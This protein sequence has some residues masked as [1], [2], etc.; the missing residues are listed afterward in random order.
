MYSNRAVLLWLL[1][2]GLVGSLAG[3][4]FTLAVLADPAAGGPVDPQSVWVAALR[5]A[6][7]LLAPASAVG[8][9]FGRRVGLGAV[10]PNRVVPGGAGVWG[11]VRPILGVS[12]AVGL[13]IAA[14]GIIGSFVFQAADFGP[15]LGNPTPVDWLARSFSAALTEEIVFRLGLMT[16]LVWV[17]AAVVRKAG[18]DRSVFWAGNTLAALVGASFHLPPLLSAATPNWGLV[19]MVVLFSGLA[20]V[21]LGWL[22]A[23]YSLVSAMLAHFVA[24]FVQHVIPRTLAMVSGY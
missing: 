5:E 13:A 6:L 19:T 22:Y 15:G 8:L 12:V 23:R 7:L 24:D 3:V 1:A 10:L 21:A 17:I 9:W 20:G 16:C 18:T 14:P 11:R 4:P 2:A